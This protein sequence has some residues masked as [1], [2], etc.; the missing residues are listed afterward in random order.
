MEKPFPG[1]DP[2]LEAP[3][4]WPDVQHSLIVAMS[5]QINQ[6]LSADYVTVISPYIAAEEIDF[7]E[8]TQ[9]TEAVQTP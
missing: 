2:Y 3:S 9:F 5:N 4:I 6:C 8:F 1:M 7:S